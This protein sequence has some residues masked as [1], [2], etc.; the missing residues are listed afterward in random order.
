MPSDERQQVGW[1]LTSLTRHIL[2]SRKGAKQL[3]VLPAVH[4]ARHMGPDAGCSGCCG[5]CMH[6]C[7]AGPL[8]C[9]APAVRVGACVCRRACTIAVGWHALFCRGVHGQS[10]RVMLAVRVVCS[11]CACV[12]ACPPILRDFHPPSTWL[13]SC[14]LSAG[15]DEGALRVRGAWEINARALGRGVPGRTGTVVDR[16][17]KSCADRRQPSLAC[18]AATSIVRLP[19][20]SPLNH[21]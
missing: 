10:M 4:P 13:G 20:H 17:H 11:A 21:A 14:M 1:C 5:R 3:Y 9:G 18:T 15:R 19:V 8:E 16:L 12:P 6:R 2:L 7:Q